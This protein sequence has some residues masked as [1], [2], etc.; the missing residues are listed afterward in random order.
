M[1]ICISGLKDKPNLSP[2]IITVTEKH[3]LIRLLQI[4]S[5]ATLLEIVL[6]DLQTSTT[7]GL[8]QRGRKLK[9]RIH[10]AVYLLQKIYD[11]TDREAEWTIKGNA[12]YQIFCGNGVVDNWHVPDHT[13]I[14]EFR[15][16][17]K[18]ETQRAL[19]NYILTLSRN[20]GFADPSK[21]DIDSTIQEPNM[22]YP[23]DATMLVKISE[24]AEKVY[25]YIDQKVTGGANKIVMKTKEI[26]GKA[27]EYFFSK[28][29]DIETKKAVLI[30]LKA[31]VV[32]QVT[33]VTQIFLTS[34]CIERMPWNIKRSW[35]QL[36]D[37][38]ANFLRVLS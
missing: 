11:M 12:A 32:E 36:K 19:N 15:S 6:P 28:Q 14:E 24:I 17:L 10:L 9:V 22:A 2:V 33:N 29:K 26:K 3:P 37:H 5:W 34:I 20:L 38:S 16:R 31:L 13:K 25:N 8:F 30:Q 4:I 1:S 35:N 18:P 23:S 27:K 7:K 21:M